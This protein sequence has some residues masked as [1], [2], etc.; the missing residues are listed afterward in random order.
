MTPPPQAESGWLANAIVGSLIMVSLATALG[1]PIGVMAGI[2][3]AEYGRRAGLGRPRGS[4][5]TSCCRRR[6]S[7]SA[8]SST[9]WWWRTTK[10]F[11]GWA[12]VLALALIVIPV[13]IRTTENM[14]SADS[15]PP[16]RGGLRAGHAQVEG[17]LV[18]IT[19]KAAR[20]A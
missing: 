6:P 1:T 19:L 4:S 8:C 20:A 2:Y 16:A 3:L 17:D 15:R 5:T 18:G 9:P 7:S 14:L 12:G 11:S 13:V 10:T